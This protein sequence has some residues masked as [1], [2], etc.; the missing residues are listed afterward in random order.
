M[1]TPELNKA[2]AAFQADLPAVA[3]GETAKVPTK[4]GGEYT[5][6][7]ADL[8]AVSDAVMK[9]LGNHGLAFTALPGTDDQGHL[10]MDYGLIHASG[11]E[12]MAQFPLW[13]L[14]P[15]RVTAQQV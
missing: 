6:D 10:V 13:L 11:E 5:Y 1:P 7:Y 14:L 3:K 4:S 9:R 2:L 15:D 8:A 12:K